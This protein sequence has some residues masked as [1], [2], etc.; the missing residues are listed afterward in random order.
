ML[1]SRLRML[2]QMQSKIN[3][4]RKRS[5]TIVAL[6]VAAAL[7]LSLIA[8]F[9]VAAGS[10]TEKA[11]A[12]DMVEETTVT[13]G[14]FTETSGSETLMTPSSWTSNAVSVIN[15]DNV[16][17]GVVDL[18]PAAL[19]DEA[20]EDLGMEAGDVI[21]T[22]F[23]SNSG[24]NMFAGSDANALFINSD[25]AD[26]V[27]GYD[28]SS[29]SLDASSYYEISAWVKTS[30]FGDGQ[31]ASLKVS[32]ME[33][34]IIIEDIDTVDYYNEKGVSQDDVN[35]S[36]YYYGW[37]EYKI[38]IA[39][40]TMS[41]PSVT[42]SLQLGSS[43][44]F[45]DPSS[46]SEEPRVI[47]DE[48]NGWAL[49]DHVT[50]KQY[51]YNTFVSRVA[52]INDTHTFIDPFEERTYAL[53]D[54]GCAL[55]YDENDSAFL[56]VDENGNILSEGD[57]DFTA[58]II[59]DFE[60]NR[61]TRW[62]SAQQS[63]G[64]Q[65]EVGAY[66]AESEELGIDNAED[67]PYSPDGEKG[68]ILMINT[69]DAKSETFK[70]ASGGVKSCDFTIERRTNYR[71]SVWVKTVGESPAG[72]VIAGDD[73]R[74]PLND[75]NDKV[76]NG[77]GQL[78]VAATQ[79]SGGDDDMRYGWSEQVFYLQGSV[80]N[81]Y[82]VHI[83][84]WLGMRAGGETSAAN[85]SG[86]AMFDSI[87]I[88]EITYDEYSTNSS[89]GTTVTFDGEA[90]DNSITNGYFDE[91]GDPD[92]DSNIY[93][94]EDWTLT[95][96]GKDETK[97]MS[98]NV[99]N[100]DYLDYT[101]A[102]IVSSDMTAYKYKVPGAADR[103][104]EGP[105][106]PKATAPDNKADNLLLI[107]A[108]DL[109]ADKDGVAVGYSSASFSASANTVQ[110]IDVKMR[111][112]NISGYGA[113]LVLKSGDK[114]VATIQRITDTNDGSFALY[115][116][117]GYMTYTFFVQTGDS[118]LSDLSL[119][120]WLGMYDKDRNMSKLSAGTIYVS[121]VTMTQLN[122]MTTDDEGNEVADE[123]SLSGARADFASRCREYKN[124]FNVSKRIP[125]FACYSTYGST[126]GGA[127][128]IYDDGA[129]K[130]SYNWSLGTVLSNAADSDDAVSFGYY[131]LSSKD[132]SVLPENYTKEGTSSDDALVI[133]NKTAAHSEVTGDVTYTLDGDSYYRLTVTAQVYI[134]VKQASADYKGAY[135]GIDE[136]EYYIDDIKSTV[137][138]KGEGVFRTFDLYIH[139]DGTAPSETE[140]STS[141][142]ATTR[143]ITIAFGIGGTDLGERAVGTMIV[144]GITVTQIDSTTFNDANDRVQNSGATAGKYEGI[145]DYTGGET[146]DAE[147][148]EDEDIGSTDA[149]GN[150][151]YIYISVVLAVVIVI[152]VIAAIVR[153]V[154][155]KKKRSGERSP[156]E[157]HSYDREI[158]LVRQHKALVE[159]E[160]ADEASGYDAFDE[161][162]EDR[163]ATMQAIAEAE[164]LAGENA[165][166]N[167]ENA[168]EATESDQ[169]P[170]PEEQ[171][172]E[173]AGTDEAPAT[174]S[175][176]PA[177]AEQPAESEQP[178]ETEQPAEETTDVEAEAAPAEQTE[179]VEEPVSEEQSAEEEEEYRYSDE[180]V[181]FTPSEDRRREI[182]A[183]KAEKARIKAEKEAA[184]KAEENARARLEAERKEATRRY[185]KWDDF[186][187]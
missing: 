152:A 143:T 41:A 176:Q 73:Y 31:G 97:G 150:N 144:S 169:S 157:R 70:S 141:T 168:P 109:P 100:D 39:T 126:I 133:T 108:E 174:E 23:G 127:Y 46:S 28:S 175:E 117:D 173:A 119:E 132:D 60:E 48:S 52:D 86:I 111:V 85:A 9:P 183:A 167:A 179:A 95:V 115:A 69:F 53:S 18:D 107:K 87:R 1:F 113:N 47:S 67:I 124:V 65:P 140:D 16:I 57:A 139:T 14:E 3:S 76:N 35:N 43:V 72:I 51:T 13:N 49:F 102:G 68:N 6:I 71:L 80:Y 159:N 137:N 63:Y 148:D 158:T 89:S 88:E 12:V 166:A 8:F 75:P 4:L 15:E 164:A 182:E 185:N 20:L 129:V 77:K 134:P 187:D 146:D 98:T 142:D 24:S 123:T 162:I 184:R 54:D 181:D 121:E 136:T 172:D 42:I 61:M 177:D 92:G 99:Y 38:Y 104:L 94:P 32:G 122:E 145:A 131:D 50:A 33:N 26:I 178:A 64:V 29:I 155:L 112:E 22:P 30:D 138:D 40:S 128:N 149:S 130:T 66:G 10:R 171:S 163:I 135:I 156:S 83:E 56:S 78:M 79:L 91:F 96:A 36:K 101:V 170:A 90:A 125:F 11:A 161:D 82:D 37:V 34:D 180:I 165:A 58:N 154:A 114:E 19:D 106:T 44:S 17:S 25:G 5:L 153:Y 45:T 105:L 62:D 93:S 74:G 120:I 103:Y 151:W 84:L 118:S 55:Y 147:E 59:G 116:G 7:V 110:R 160:T 27:Y 186:E 21:R 2:I 81:D